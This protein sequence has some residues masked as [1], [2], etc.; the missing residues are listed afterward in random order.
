MISLSAA[1]SFWYTKGPYPSKCSLGYWKAGDVLVDVFRYLCRHKSIHS[2]WH[3]L[4]IN[5]HQGPYIE[6]TDIIW[7]GQG[8]QCISTVSTVSLQRLFSLLSWCDETSLFLP[9]STHS[10]SY[11]RGHLVTWYRD[12]HSHSGLWCTRTGTKQ[13]IQF[14]SGMLP[15]VT[16]VHHTV[17][18]VQSVSQPA[19]HLGNIH[20][21]DGI[22]DRH[23]S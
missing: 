5:K 8:I 22:L 18:L 21:P 12:A 17:R 11:C 16:Y 23:T 9:T 1:I 3:L 14:L 10:H 19:S 13:N 20:R 15:C 4:S 6:S 2:V 7:E